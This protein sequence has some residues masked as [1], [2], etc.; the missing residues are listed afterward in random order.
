V[1][2]NGAGSVAQWLG[3]SPLEDLF[4][5]APNLWF[6][7]DHFIGKLSAMGQPAWQIY[8]YYGSGDH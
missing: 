2:R 1:A 4:S 6:T 3:P 7:G 5:L 8:M